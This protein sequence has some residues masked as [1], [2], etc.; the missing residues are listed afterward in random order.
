M[1]KLIGKTCKVNHWVLHFYY[2]VLDLADLMKTC[3]ERM[4]FLNLAGSNGAPYR[5]T[6]GTG[7]IHQQV[8]IFVY[9]FQLSRRAGEPPVLRNW[10]YL[11][12]G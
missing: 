12:R 8:P 1:L 11:L 4:I 2:D 6:Q 10:Q 9:R 7:T 5:S 3:Q